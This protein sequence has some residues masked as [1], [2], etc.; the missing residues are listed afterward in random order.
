[1]ALKLTGEFD[2]GNGENY[3]LYYGARHETVSQVCD[4]LGIKT[5]SGK[6]ND[7]DVW[8]TN[9]GAT[10]PKLTDSVPD[11][12]DNCLGIRLSA[13]SKADCLP[14]AAQAYKKQHA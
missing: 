5:T 6:L 13:I 7:K 10:T 12:D 8:Y 14:Q 4:R 9:K 1:M 3:I 11:G 2:Y